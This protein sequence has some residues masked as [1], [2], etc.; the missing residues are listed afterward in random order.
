MP[1]TIRVQATTNTVRTVSGNQLTIYQMG[2]INTGGGGG[3]GDHP[4]VDHDSFVSLTT[5][6]TI[7]GQKTFTNYTD[8]QETDD[9]AARFITSL[10]INAINKH[11]VEIGY[12]ATTGDDRTALNVYSNNEDESAFWLSGIEK[13]AG[14]LKITHNEPT[15]DD[16]NASAISIFHAGTASAA[17]G[18]FIDS[19]HSLTGH[20]LDLRNNGSQVFYIRSN[21]NPMVKST[22]PV[23]ELWDTDSTAGKQ[24]YALVAGGNTFNLRRL[25]DNGSEVDTPIS[26][27]T[28]GRVNV[29]APVD[30]T[31]A[32]TKDYVDTNFEPTHAHPYLADTHASG[33]HSYADT[34]I[35]TAGHDGKLTGATTVGAA[36]VILDNADYGATSADLSNHEADTTSI[37]GIADTSALITGIVVQDEN[38]TVATT[39]QLDF[40]GT[41]IVAT[42]GAGEA[43]ITVNAYEAGTGTSMTP[44]A[45]I[46][47]G[48]STGTPS[49]PSNGDIWIQTT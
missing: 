37:H 33:D 8:F 5:N 13:N 17:K 19:N 38:S 14:T 42:G 29:P 22:N 3:G 44:T 49:S 6:E 48:P 4:D 24:R 9:R 26:I 46:Y 10:E 41:A 34:D 7:S 30:A 40:Q 16:S 43:V 21:G 2:V 15:V 18:I 47:I 28:N 36:L 39:D 11:T 27:D 20:F 35:S 1:E 31:N 12:Q 45:K 23:Y 25:A 32:A